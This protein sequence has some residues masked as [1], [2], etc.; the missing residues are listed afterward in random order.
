MTKNKN[1]EREQIKL[2]IATIVS[3]NKE[4]LKS[5]DFYRRVVRHMILAGCKG[6]SAELDTLNNPNLMVIGTPQDIESWRK[7]HGITLAMPYLLQN[8]V[9][10]STGAQFV[11]DV[12]VKEI[13]STKLLQWIDDEIYAIYSYNSPDGYYHGTPKH[14]AAVLQN[15]IFT[16]LGNIVVH[17]ITRHIF[18]AS[19]CTIQGTFLYPD[20]PWIRDWCKPHPTDAEDTLTSSP[21]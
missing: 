8:T 21:A 16:G 6:L 15:T 20:H 2:E 12:A 9:P 10:H 14:R 13:M 17:Y 4:F 11:A 5:I 3:E 19:P 7:R 1:S 18:W